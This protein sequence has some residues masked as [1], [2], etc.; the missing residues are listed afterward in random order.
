MNFPKADWQTAL[1]NAVTE[2]KELFSLLQLDD[3][4]LEVA[5]QA[6][7]RFPLKVPHSFIAR[8]EKKNI[9]DPLLRQVLPIEAELQDIA[10]YF[11]D[12]LEESSCNPI[13]GL[14]HKYQARVLLTYTAICAINCRY[15]FRRE[16]PYNKN[17]PGSAGWNDALDYISHDD[18]IREVILSG[19]D[20]LVANDTTLKNIVEKIADI[21]HITRLRIHSRMPVVLPERVTP[22]LIQLL[23]NTRLKPVMVVHC[24]HAQE[25]N[26]EVRDTMRRMTDARIPLLN[27]SVLLRGI[28]DNEDAL[29]SLSEAL[30]D[31]G[32]LPYYLHVLDKV[33][34]TAHFDLTRQTAV[35]LH[36]GMMKRLP[37]YL[38]PRLVCEQAGAFSK[39]YIHA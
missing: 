35:N 7:A 39:L 30:F 33:K 1:I 19:G 31:A 11:A 22:E 28:N 2:P 34:G 10:G 24:N 38:V 17:N 29:V 25:I 18:S 8:M 26:D 20:P 36:Q 6:A 27:Q 3:D 15:C 4:L 13:P 16:F 12:P 9:N 32:I 14:L 5:Y 23:V 37:G 21:S